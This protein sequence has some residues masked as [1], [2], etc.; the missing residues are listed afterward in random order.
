MKNK[1]LVFVILAI[2]FVACKP[3]ERIINHTEYVSKIKYDSIYFA[4]HDSVYVEKKGDTLRISTFQT[5]YIER[6]RIQKDTVNKTDTLTVL[7][8]GQAKIQTEEIKGFFWWVGF[9]LV[10][11]LAAS[12]VFKLVTWSPIKSVFKKLLNIN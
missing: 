1:I 7:V 2:S 8:P 4:Q 6:F 5:I 9:I 12:A 11:V 3:T 10:I